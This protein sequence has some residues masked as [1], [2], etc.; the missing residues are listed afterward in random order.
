M[1][2][3][4]KVKM[5]YLQKFW[6]EAYPIFM[7]YRRTVAALNAASTFQSSNAFGNA[8]ATNEDRRLIFA[9]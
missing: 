1:P 6:I 3:V 2:A 7:S 5:H 8:S 4:Y 9:Q